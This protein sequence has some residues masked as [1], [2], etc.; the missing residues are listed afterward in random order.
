MHDEDSLPICVAPLLGDG[1]TYHRQTKKKMKRISFTLL[2]SLLLT[3]SAFGRTVV[4]QP[5][6][7]AVVA[8][9]AFF[10]PDGNMN[11]GFYIY[12]EQGI[13]GSPVGCTFSFQGFSNFSNAGLTAQVVAVSPATGVQQFQLLSAVPV[14][15]IGVTYSCATTF[16]TAGNF[17]L[18]F[19]PTPTVSLVFPNQLGT[20][21]PCANPHLIPVNTSIPDI[22]VT[23]KI[24][25]NGG[26]STQIYVCGVSISFGGTAAGTIQFKQGTGTNCATG[27]GLL[28]GT[29]TGVLGTMPSI[30][31]AGRTAIP[32]PVAKDLCLVVAGGTAP[33]IGGFISTITQ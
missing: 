28:S 16:P 21:D 8:S 29:F 6:T 11:S 1:F 22:A 17:S 7:S 27:G 26:G 32:V 33:T 23:T 18:E 13:T 12:M 9:T 10:L 4:F 15:S 24:V 14:D 2:A 30:G 19:I 5:T 3:L 31:F 25:S 20:D